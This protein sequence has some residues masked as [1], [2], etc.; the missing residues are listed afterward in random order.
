MRLKEID[1]GREFT[2]PELHREWR[3]FRAEDIVNHADNFPTELYEI[4]MATVNG[5]NDCEVIG[6]RPTELEGFITALRT[7][8][9]RRRLA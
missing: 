8:I 5:R 1:T 6:L 9:D 4:L 7:T 3:E 2:L